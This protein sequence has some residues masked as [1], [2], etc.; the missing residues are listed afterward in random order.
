MRRSITYLVFLSCLMALTPLYAATQTL[1]TYYPAPNGNYLNLTVNQVFTLV[2]TAACSYS[3]TNVGVADIG[4]VFE[5]CDSSGTY[6]IT[7]N[8]LWT[9]NGTIIYPTSSTQNVVVGATT[10]PAGT[11]LYVS[12]TADITGATTIGGAATLSSSLSVATTATVGGLASLNGGLSVTGTASVSGLATLNGGVQVNGNANVTGTTTLG[13]GS[14]NATTVN[15]AASLNNGATVAGAPLSINT[16]IQY[17]SGGCG[18]LEVA[19]GSD[20]NYYAVY[21][22]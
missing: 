21:G 20:G 12:G 16:S 14:G 17:C 3:G 5:I 8:D 1:T 22:P 10:D 9:G 2:A 6:P 13:A 7:K 4:G 19:K 15:G 18:T 11:A